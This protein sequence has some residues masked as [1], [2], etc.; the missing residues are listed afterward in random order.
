[1]VAF[2]QRFLRMRCLTCLFIVTIQSSLK[3]PYFSVLLKNLKYLDL[4]YRMDLDLW[5][6]LGRVKLI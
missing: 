1:M 6:C 2:T 4:S 3:I 5:D